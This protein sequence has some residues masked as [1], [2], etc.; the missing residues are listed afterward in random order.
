MTAL[1]LKTT[2]VLASTW[3]LPN[4][5]RVL[6]CLAGTEPTLP[7]SQGCQSTEFT[8]GQKKKN[9]S[10]NFEGLYPCERRAERPA[11]KMAR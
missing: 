6:A 9:S 4:L 5:L 2:R 3:A 11:L 10:A 8:S 1:V 7:H